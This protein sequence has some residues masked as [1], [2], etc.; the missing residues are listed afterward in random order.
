MKWSDVKR[1]TDYQVS[2]SAVS[3]DAK[4]HPLTDASERVFNIES[5]AKKEGFDCSV[6]DA[7]S[8]NID[9]NSELSSITLI[10]FKGGTNPYE[11]EDHKDNTFYKKAFDTIHIVLRELI[12]D[13]DI[14]QKIFSDDCSLRYLICL[15]SK[16]ILFSTASTSKEKLHTRAKTINMR[17][18]VRKTEIFSSISKCRERHPFSEIEVIQA[19]KVKSYIS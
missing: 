12:G 6:V 4:G 14:W 7:L 9:K 1:M 16:N 3:V 15:S 17:N 5:Y 13:T 18:K 11:W 10:E 8:L 2:L 19:D